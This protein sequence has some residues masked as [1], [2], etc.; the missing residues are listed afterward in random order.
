MILRILPH[1]VCLV[2]L[3]TLPHGVC[4]SYELMENVFPS[5]HLFSSCHRLGKGSPMAVLSLADPSKKDSGSK[6]FTE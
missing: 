6:V 2:T 1:G 5:S 3:R 4:L